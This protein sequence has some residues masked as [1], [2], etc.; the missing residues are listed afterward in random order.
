MTLENAHVCFL[1]FMK[2]TRG[3]TRVLIERVCIKPSVEHR[4][5]FQKTYSCHHLIYQE[6]SPIIYGDFFVGKMLL[7]L[8]F[9]KTFSSGQKRCVV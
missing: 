5:I 8:F 7:R 4:R 9:Q 3:F 2:S 6:K 1:Y